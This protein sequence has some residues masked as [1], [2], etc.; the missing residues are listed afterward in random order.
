MPVYTVWRKTWAW[1]G[2]STRSLYPSYS[3][4]TVYVSPAIL[5]L[6]ETNRASVVRSP[7]KPSHQETQTLPLHCL[8][9]RY[10]GHHRNLDR[11][12]PK[13]R[14]PDRM[15]HPP[16]RRRSRPLPRH[17]DL[18]HTFLQQAR[19]RP[20]H[21]VPIQQFSRSRRIWRVTRVWNRIYGWHQ[22]PARL[23]MD[24]DH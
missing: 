8:N 1:S 10:M 17:D 13:L 3:S 9:L 15:S 21:R 4:H 12:L 5:S 6:T 11:N 2:I 24:H 7:F 20:A 23:A 16:R 22:R 19:N 14:R 18:P